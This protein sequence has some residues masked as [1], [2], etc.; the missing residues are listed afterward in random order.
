M[1]SHQFGTFLK[2]FQFWCIIK[3]D[4]VLFLK[5]LLIIFWSV[6]VGA[7]EQEELTSGLICT[8]VR[9]RQCWLEETEYLL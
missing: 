9:R 7:Q 4:S 6:S 3:N 5:Q 8:H 2:W 1:W